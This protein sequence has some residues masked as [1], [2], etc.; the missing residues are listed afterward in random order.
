MGGCSDNGGTIMM[1]CI[2]HLDKGCSV[3]CHAGTCSR[4][5]TRHCASCC[6]R[7]DNSYGASSCNRRGTRYRVSVCSRS[8][9]RYSVPVVV[10]TVEAV[11][12]VSVVVTGIC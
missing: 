1:S 4:G 11:G 6:S 9:T 2:K 10:G 8:G 12:G 5:G 3:R 7:S